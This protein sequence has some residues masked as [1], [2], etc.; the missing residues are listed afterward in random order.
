[1]YSVGFDSVARSFWN[2][3][4]GDN[5]ILYIHLGGTYTDIVVDG[6]A[7]E[8]IADLRTGIVIPPHQNSPATSARSLPALHDPLDQQFAEV[9]SEEAAAVSAG[10]EANDAVDAAKKAFSSALDAADSGVKDWADEYVEEAVRS[11][12]KALSPFVPQFMEELL[13]DYT[14]RFIDANA[15]LLKRVFKSKVWQRVSRNPNQLVTDLRPR[16]TNFVSERAN[17]LSDSAATLAAQAKKARNGKDFDTA[18]RDLKQS[19]DRASDAANTLQ[20][21]GHSEAPDSDG[22]LIIA[23]AKEHTTQ[24]A[25]VLKDAEEHAEDSEGIAAWKEALEKAISIGAKAAERM[26]K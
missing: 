24:V 1:V 12:A 23:T 18:N 14:D 3:Q 26:P 21:F 25:G 8:D 22:A 4:F 11:Y 10:K 19:E 2:S 17:Q 7:R 13:S 5:D 9:R 6:Y 20:W 16:F 15:E